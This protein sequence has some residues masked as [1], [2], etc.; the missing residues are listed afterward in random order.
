MAIQIFT[1][2]EINSFRKGG[3]ILR[4]CLDMLPQYVKEGVTTKRLD[5]LAEMYIRDHGGIPAFKGYH[6]FPATLCTSVNEQCVH[7]IPGAYELKDGDI[8]SL[9]C[10]VIFDE[11]YTDACISV[12]IGNISKE[13]TNLLHVTKK[14]LDEAVAFLK[15]GVRVGD[16]SSLIQKSVERGGCRAVRSLTG[17]GLGRSLHQFPDIPNLGKPGTGPVFPA[18]TVVAVEPIVA[19]SADDVETAGDGWTLVTE[20]GSLSAHF[21]H[22][23]LILVDGCEVIA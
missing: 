12:G 19:I 16:V 8:I 2:E 7:A 22:T 23:L 4:G 9:D 11:L 20:D 5:E 10:G 13:A 21:E 15:A 6:D 1:D 3:K 14:A 18:H 17:H